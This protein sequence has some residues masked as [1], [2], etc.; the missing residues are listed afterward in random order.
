MSKVVGIDFG[1]TN[2]LVAV[3]TPDGP[4]V[5]FD[6]NGDKLTPSV[7]AKHNQNLYVGK[8]AKENIKAFID[9]EGIK[10]I[11]RKIGSSEKIH[12]A[13]EFFKPYEIAGMILKKAKQ[14]IDLY[15]GEDIKKA[16]ITVP[17]EFSDSQ[18][19]E[20]IEAGKIAGFEVE[21]II[22]EP[23]A[24]L[25]AYAYTNQVSNKVVLCYDF[26]GGTFD[27]SIA[28]VSGEGVKVRCV[29]GDRYLGGSD[30]DKSFFQVIKQEVEGTKN[31]KLNPYGERRL[32]LALEGAKIELSVKERTTIN[33]PLLETEN[34]GMV[35][36]FKRISREKLES[37][38]EPYIDKT[39][40]IVQ[41]VLAEN[42]IDP[43]LDI[44]EVL[45]I[46]GSAQIPLV[47]ERLTAIFGKEPITGDMLT[48]ES[49]AL[50]AALEAGHRQGA[51]KG[52]GPKILLDV[53]PYTIGL[54]ITENGKKD[55]FDPIIHK[56]FAY[57][58]EFSENYVTIHDNQTSMLL[59]IYQGE[60]RITSKNEHICNLEIEGIP[61]REAGKEIVKVT[62]MY[63]E[64]GIIHI[65]AVILS[66][67]K[68]IVKFIPFNRRFSNR[69]TEDS[70]QSIQ[71]HFISEEELSNATSLSQQL[72]K[73]GLEKERE[74]LE[75]ALRNEN[76]TELLRIMNDLLE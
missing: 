70:K 68:E 4:K 41:T 1:T 37:I 67:A 25:M 18:R 43:L 23:T 63:D 39:I 73:Q 72:K 15:F 61:E 76:R 74:W 57:S 2:T 71:K 7:V 46:G 55:I 42:G 56:N 19:K 62:F 11:K 60:S 10:E 22:N 50:G 21:K 31:C 59:E 35:S 29:G 65:K 5:I 49:V 3:T 52:I 69:Q 26:G 64:N 14:N 66:T 54:K 9:G 30:L 40:A 33:L 13:G 16:I 47:K 12:F 17:A 28:E 27:V 75:K 45:L 36:F 34:G 53:S 48:D 6:H 58:R 51:E 44:D 32:I 38:I 20:I 24:A 8:E